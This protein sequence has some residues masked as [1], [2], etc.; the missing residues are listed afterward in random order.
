MVGRMST[1]FPCLTAPPPPETWRPNNVRA[2]VAGP[3]AATVDSRA[4]TLPIDHVALSRGRPDGMYVAGKR[5]RPWLTFE[6]R[7]RLSQ[8]QGERDYNT[9][10]QAD[11]VVLASLEKAALGE[12]V[13]LRWSIENG[14]PS[15]AAVSV[16]EEWISQG[17]T[18]KSAY[19]WAPT[20]ADG[21]RHVHVCNLRHA[22]VTWALEAM[23]R[24]R[25]GSNNY[26]KLVTPICDAFGD[27]WVLPIADVC[28]LIANADVGAARKA[29]KDAQAV[30]KRWAA[31]PSKES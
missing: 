22:L 11:R 16:S 25:D 29:L 21:H 26:Y 15:A 7:R 18:R 28:R 1:D 10:R 31:T 20:D 2:C 12:S 30:A 14:H 24:P 6:E 19:T 13:V 5:L 8:L 23:G 3:V 9:I 4:P 27:E 17:V